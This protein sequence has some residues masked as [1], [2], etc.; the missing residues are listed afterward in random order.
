MQ[1]WRVSPSTEATLFAY[2]VLLWLSLSAVVELSLC[3]LQSLFAQIDLYE[4]RSHWLRRKTTATFYRECSRDWDNLHFLSIPLCL[5]ESSFVSKTVPMGRLRTGAKRNWLIQMLSGLSAY[6]RT[7]GARKAW[8]CLPLSVHFCC[9]T[10]G[11]RTKPIPSSYETQEPGGPGFMP[12]ALLG[13]VQS[14]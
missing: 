1:I 2:W 10:S 13:L 6:A 11:L 4:V 9:P 5:F 12:Y 7:P 8:Q 14:L 3:L